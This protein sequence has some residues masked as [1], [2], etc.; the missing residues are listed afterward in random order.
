MT[1]ARWAWSATHASTRPRGSCSH[2]CYTPRWKCVFA[3]ASRRVCKALH[4]ANYL[5][6][7]L[8]ICA[9]LHLQAHHNT[10]ATDAMWFIAMMLGLGLLG[11]IWS[12]SS[13]A[14]HGAGLGTLLLRFLDLGTAVLPALL[15]LLPAAPA[16][17]YMRWCRSMLWARHAD[18]SAPP[19][20]R[21]FG[22]ASSDHC[23]AA[24]PA[25]LPGSV[26]GIC[27]GQAESSRHLCLQS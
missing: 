1:Q 16:S 17:A 12:M 25:C 24:C 21:C 22:S 27:S 26:G 3:S 2:P 4:A 19:S 13:F 14:V 15:L 18:A 11:F 10:F 5:Q 6:I 23:C 9:V 7:I 8:Q 20:Q